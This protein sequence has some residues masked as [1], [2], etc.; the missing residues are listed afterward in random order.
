[1]EG[2]S[3]LDRLL[4]EFPEAPLAV[5]VVWE[6]VLPTDIAAP[7]SSVLGRIT[8]RRVRQY[9][10]P[11]QTLS[12]EIRAAVN[13]DPARYGLDEPLPADFVVWDVVA[14]FGR[15]VR[16]GDALPVPVYYGGPVRTVIDP[17]REAITAAIAGRMEPSAGGG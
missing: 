2:A 8:D 11:G 12:G 14:V 15:S 17:A 5:L 16:F 7:L 1:M 3:A 9:W 13:A 4:A 10:D 6:P